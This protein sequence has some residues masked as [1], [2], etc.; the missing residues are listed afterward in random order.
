[1]A[2]Y[3]IARVGRQQAPEVDVENQQ[4]GR[5]GAE[6]VGVKAA[7]DDE[8]V[9]ALSGFDGVLNYGG[10]FPAAV[11][12]RLDSVWI[13]V[14]AST[15]YDAIDDD[16]ATEAGIMVANLPFQCLDE[17]A[18]SALGY[19]LTLNRR[20]VEADRHVRA[21]GW[22]R[23]SFMPIGTLYGE[24][25]G[26]L[27]FGNI[28]RA[29]ARRGQALAMKVIAHDPYVDPQIAREM[30]VELLPLEDVLKRSD[31]VSC[32]L[33][34]NRHSHHMLSQAQFRLMKPS[35][36]FVNTSRGKVVDEPA[37]IRAL[38]E[39][40]IAGAGLDVFEQEPLPADSPLRKL[41]NVL[42]APH[43]AGT[44]VG[45]AVNNRQQAI[46]QMAEALET[47]KPSA[48]VNRSVVSRRLVAR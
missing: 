36:F 14:Q 23:F 47:G 10:R 46:D 11:I 5:L 8:L 2:R 30:G 22:D 20:L 33:P 44:S 6:V 1:M 15:G 48:L 12:K 18:N 26:L 34:H 16:A 45:S 42:L 24:T 27:G 41:E 9:A 3:R 7:S 19:I 25:L 31:Y 35:A 32:H 13:I 43:L 40:W 38:Q 29:V 4:L 28:S 39:R 37:L 17:V 21:G